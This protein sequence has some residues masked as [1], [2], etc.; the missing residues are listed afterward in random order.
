MIPQKIQ[1]LF[2][3]IDF[4]DEHKSE[5]IEKY[6]PLCEELKELDRQRNL[7]KPN[8][9]YQDKQTFDNIQDRIEEKFKPITEGVYKPITNKLKELGIWAGDDVYS[10]I[11]NN[12]ISEISEFKRNFSN[13][14][15]E[16][17]FEYKHK[18]L[19]FRIKTNSDFLSLTFIFQSLDEILKELFDFFKDTD[20]NEFDKFETKR[21][22]L[23]NLSE[24]AKGISENKGKNVSF[25]IPLDTLYS[26][27]QTS[28]QSTD[29]KHEIIMGDKIEVGNINNNAGQI[30]VGKNNKTERKSNDELA[31]KTFNWQKWGIIIG[32]IL[33]IMA[34]TVT[35]IFSGK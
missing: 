16:Q 19:D 31:K 24:L 34:I 35:I 22:V 23:E 21:I 2:E 13:E 1:V 30:S 8:N 11:W 6:I 29:T 12:N 5:Y 28:K 27:K 33:T 15:T 4:L 26:K 10:S 17:I 18:Y 20:V 3:F 7:L 14:D 9:N 32:I 25:S